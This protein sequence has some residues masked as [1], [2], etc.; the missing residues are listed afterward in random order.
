MEYSEIKFISPKKLVPYKANSKTHPQEQ[1][2]KI[3]KLMKKWGFPESKAILVDENLEILHGHGRREASIFAELKTVPYQVV[4]G[5]SE[6][7]KKAWR[8]ADNAVSESEW[9][10]E[11][12]KEEYALLTDL[13]YDVSILGLDE[14]HLNM[15]TENEFEGDFEEN[16]TLAIDF[17]PTENSTS[18]NLNYLKFGNNSIPLSE[19]EL[20]YLENK[21]KEYNEQFGVNSGFIGHL[22]GV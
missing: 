19:K 10:Y 6:E 22:L 17:D 8:I 16:E 9:D 1:I 3:A 13:D 21:L 18:A 20:D 14:E 7:D 5:L 2:E 11:L 4:S 15:L 12:L